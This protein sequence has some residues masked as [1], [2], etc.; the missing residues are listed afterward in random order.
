MTLKL[1]VLY[2]N[3]RLLLITNREKPCLSYLLNLVILYSVETVIL[4]CIIHSL[5]LSPIE[6]LGTLGSLTS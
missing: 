2:L 4:N 1:Y 6:F 3:T 5:E